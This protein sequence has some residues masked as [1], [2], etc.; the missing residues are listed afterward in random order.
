MSAAS[1]QV[2]GPGARTAI[3]TTAAAE[4]AVSA[5]STLEARRA[6]HQLA[7]PSVAFGV[8]RKAVRE[9]R[10]PPRQASAPTQLRA[11]QI[12]MAP[13]ASLHRQPVLAFN[14]HSARAR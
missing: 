10:R 9:R 4:T 12:R 6:R 2:V 13:T 7:W 3:A 5:V 8:R 14:A 11:N 1:A